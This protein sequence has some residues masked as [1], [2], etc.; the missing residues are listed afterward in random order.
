MVRPDVLLPKNGLT[1]AIL[2]DQAMLIVSPDASGITGFPKLAGKRLGIAAHKSADFWLLK[3]ILAY[4][5]LLL[6]T[7]T[8]PATVPVPGTRSASSP[9]TGRR[10]RRRSATSASMPM[11]ASSR[12]PPRRRG[13]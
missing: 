1:L 7:E 3:N 10:R 9:S 11:S 4:Y 8:V 12:P 2:R 6:E 5:N 13:R